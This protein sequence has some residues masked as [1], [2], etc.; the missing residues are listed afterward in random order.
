MVSASG[1]T[2][3]RNPKSIIIERQQPR[4]SENGKLQ[5]LKREEERRD[6]TPRWERR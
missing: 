2:P 3:Y 6:K 5:R 4:N 1:K